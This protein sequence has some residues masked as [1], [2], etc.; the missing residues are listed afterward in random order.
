VL[1]PHDDCEAFETEVKTGA[2]KTATKKYSERVIA[3]LALRLRDRL[4]EE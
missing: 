1:R 4:Y 2:A 3:P